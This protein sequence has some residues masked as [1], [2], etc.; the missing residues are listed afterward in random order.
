[1]KTSEFENLQ[2]NGNIE[3]NDEEFEKRMKL[4]EEEIA[5]RDAA[6]QILIEQEKHRLRMVE[7]EAE[8]EAKRKQ[9]EEEKKQAD[10]EKKDRRRK[11]NKE[12][13]RLRESY[14]E[15]PEDLMRVADGLIQRAAFMRI[16]LE[17]Y[18]R[19]LEENGHVELFSQSPTT[20][21]YERQRPVAQLYNTMNANYQKIIKQLA[22]LVPPTPPP[23]KEP[24]KKDEF[25]QILERGNGK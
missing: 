1:M 24:P 9:E 2:K 17:E 21:P 14:K 20:K 18:E 10:K 25:E 19:D 7:M 4:S 11:L 6:A 23:L 12:E 22:E 15:L 8:R 13:N 3:E 16:T 5:R